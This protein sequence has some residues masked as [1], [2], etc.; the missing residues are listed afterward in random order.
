MMKIF[1]KKNQKNSKT[2]KLKI[3]LGFKFVAIMGFTLI[4]VMTLIGFVVI[5][6]AKK[7]IATDMKKKGQLYSSFLADFSKQIIVETPTKSDLSLMQNYLNNLIE[8]NEDIIYAYITDENDTPIVHSRSKKTSLKGTLVIAL[9]ITSAGKKIGTVKMWYST[10]YVI[11]ELSSNMKNVLILVIIVAFFV[12]GTTMFLFSER[13]I[14]RRIGLLIKSMVRVK[15]GVL[16]VQITDTTQDEIGVLSQNFNEML[17]EIEEKHKELT[18]LFEMSQTITSSLHVNLVLDM[19]MDIAVDK[20]GIASGTVFMLEEEYLNIKS[21]RGLS[22]NFVQGM[23][24]QTLRKSIQNSFDEA[25][26]IV[27]ND[28]FTESSQFRDIMEKEDFRSLVNIPLVISG[29]VLGILNMNAKDK[30][31]FSERKMRLISAF[32]KQMTVS[33]QNALLYERTQQF[34]QELEE[35]I[36]I[37]TGNL[38]AVNEELSRA[39]ERLEELSRAKSEFVSIVSHELRSPLTSIS[40]FVNLMLEGETGEINSAQKEF[41]EI[42][43]ENTKRLITLIEDLLSL[44]KI[45][46]G[47]MTDLRKESLNLSRLLKEVIFSFQTQIEKKVLILKINV[48]PEPLPEL[49]ADRYQIIQ[50]LTNLLSNAIKYTPKNGQ[51]CIE[52]TKI[53]DYLQI[54]FADNG[55]GISEED[56]THMFEKFYRTDNPEVRKLSG[57]GLGL[58]ITKSIIEMHGGKIWV[59]S[60]IGKGSKFY[61]TLPLID[62]KSDVK[63]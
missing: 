16:N 33:L 35:K 61:F 40:G 48:S 23:G 49:K 52:V 45:E 58:T 6:E 57:T 5:N 24:F 22:A 9:P 4:L 18:I 38:M 51:I 10:D 21:S 42:I 31:T 15:E 2:S 50:V 19:V 47:G 36:N 43:N 37:A 3:T 34:T 56:L 46:T 29:K 28:F 14:F 12:L 20:L 11:N 39:N 27:I 53:S 54:L 63:C 17:K 59:E 7:T 55:I 62:Q 60:E 41:M 1:G 8:N 30:D 13:I 32:A 44:S 26:V 25:K